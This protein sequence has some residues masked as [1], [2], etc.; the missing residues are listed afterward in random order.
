[1]TVEVALLVSAV[2]VIVWSVRVVTVIA[3]GAAPLDYRLGRGV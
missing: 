1:M 2:L 3:G